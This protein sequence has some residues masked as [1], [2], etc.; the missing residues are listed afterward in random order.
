GRREVGTSCS[1]VGLLRSENRGGGSNPGFSLALD[2]T[3]RDGSVQP[4]REGWA[5]GLATGDREACGG[6]AQTVG[7]IGARL[8]DERAHSRADD[9]GVPFRKLHDLVRAQERAAGVGLLERSARGER[10]GSAHASPLEGNCLLTG[11]LA[12]LLGRFEVGGGEGDVKRAVGGDALGFSVCGD[13]LADVLDNDVD[14][15]SITA[16]VSEGGFNDGHFSECREL[17]ENHEDR[18]AIDLCG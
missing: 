3:G 10:G 6:G 4:V 14:L 17:V 2:G 5:G 8:D 16:Q 12:E 7:E 18:P 9:E 15:D 11:G 1:L 13:Q